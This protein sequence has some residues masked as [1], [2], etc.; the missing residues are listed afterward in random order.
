MFMPPQDQLSE[1][2]IQEGE[3]QATFNVQLFAAACATLWLSPH[4]I[5]WARKLF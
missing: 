5:D 3:A 4:V 1:K 2:E